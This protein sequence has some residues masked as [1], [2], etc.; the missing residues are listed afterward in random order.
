MVRKACTFKNKPL[1]NTCNL[2]KSLKLI[3]VVFAWT[4]YM[5]NLAKEFIT[6]M[7]FERCK[8]HPSTHRHTYPITF[9]SLSCT[10]NTLFVIES[11]SVLHIDLSSLYQNLVFLAKFT[12]SNYLSCIVSHSPKFADCIQWCELVFQSLIFAVN[13]QF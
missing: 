4:Q 1:L 11:K 5:I 3:E 13:C 6:W 9:T 12:Y 10:V 8:T 7:N 2:S